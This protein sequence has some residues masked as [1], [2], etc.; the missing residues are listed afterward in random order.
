MLAEQKRFVY[1]NM[2]DYLNT[3]DLLGVHCRYSVWLGVLSI[4]DL[5]LRFFP[6]SGY[7]GLIKFLG[8][9]MGYQ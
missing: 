8:Y 1:G 4:S 2:V 3:G 5:I 7:T 9:E 6:G